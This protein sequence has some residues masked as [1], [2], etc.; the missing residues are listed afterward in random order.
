MSPLPIRSKHL[1][2]VK[3]VASMFNLQVNCNCCG[4][5]ETVS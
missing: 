2:I 3:I 5:V 1:K 4:H